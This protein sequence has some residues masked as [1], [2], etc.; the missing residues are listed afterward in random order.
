MGMRGVYR[1]IV[2]NERPIHAESDDD[3]PTESVVT[4]G[5]VGHDQGRDLRHAVSPS[6]WRRSRIA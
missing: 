3:Y 4:T 1:E 2:P 6:T 5:L